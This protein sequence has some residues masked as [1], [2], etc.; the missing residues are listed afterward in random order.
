MPQRH[1]TLSTR[2]ISVLSKTD[3]PMKAHQIARRLGCQCNCVR[4]ILGRLCDKNSIA[5]EENSYG[6][7]YSL[8]DHS[9]PP[10]WQITMSWSMRH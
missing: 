1:I 5:R 2:V 4:V 7:F 9:S 6:V 8:P 10:I 3:E